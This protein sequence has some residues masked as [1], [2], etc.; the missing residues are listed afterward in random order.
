MTESIALS[1]LTALAGTCA[2]VFAQSAS[3]PAWLAP[4]AAAAAIVAGLGVIGWQVRRVWLS[5]HRPPATTGTGAPAGEVGQFA[6]E[7]AE[8]VERLGAVL[9]AK[10]AR[11][12][13][14]LDEADRKIRELDGLGTGAP[15]RDGFADRSRIAAGPRPQT[16]DAEHSPVGGGIQERILGLAERGLKPVEIATQLQ[17]PVGQVELVIALNRGAVRL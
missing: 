7:A 6:R 10:A 3:A 1:V 5:K 2:G 13:R 4:G 12:E 16:R 8:V 15:R 17:Q 11:I 14:L 9:D